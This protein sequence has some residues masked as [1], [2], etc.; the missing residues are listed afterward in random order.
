MLPVA[1]SPTF[2][3]DAAEYLIGTSSLERLV[4]L[5]GLT[6]EAVASLLGDPATQREVEHQ[7]AQAERSGEVVRWRAREGLAAAVAQLQQV[8][9]NPETPASTL[10]KAGEL[11]AKLAG[12]AQPSA[13]AVAKSGFSI[14]IVL[15]GDEAP[16]TLGQCANDVIDAT[17]REVGTDE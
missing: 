16:I 7:L 9:A 5:S 4:G 13:P 10:I 6:A 12:L 8:C 2:A 11:L 15:G 14:T 1:K 17:S 3:Y